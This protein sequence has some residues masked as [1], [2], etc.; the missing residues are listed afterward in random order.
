MPWWGWLAL[1]GG[2]LLLVALAGLLAAR[3][4]RLRALVEIVEEAGWRRGL[5]AIWGLVRHPGVPIWVRLVPVP[6]LLY[7]VFPIDL[8]PDFLPVVGQLDDLLV[9]AAALW[10]VVRFTPWGV[11]RELLGLEA[12]TFD[13]VEDPD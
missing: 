1:I 7:L 3:D 2:P 8:I 11:L 13:E 9:A 4:P 12:A 6:L 5:R 10:I